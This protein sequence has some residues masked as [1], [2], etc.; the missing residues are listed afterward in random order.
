[1]RCLSAS[2]RQVLRTSDVSVREAGFLNDLA[3]A[4]L[5]FSFLVK[6]LQN[7]Q[8]QPAPLSGNPQMREPHAVELAGIK[9]RVL[10]LLPFSSLLSVST[11]LAYFAARV[12][13]LA[14][15]YRTRVDRL[16]VVN[17]ILYLITE[18]GIFGRPP[19]GKQAI[20]SCCLFTDCACASVPGF[21]NHL[22]RCLAF[23]GRTK[24]PHLRLLG[25][26]DLP[27]VDVLITCAGEDFETVRNTIAAACAL[28]YPEDRFRVVVLD[29]AGSKDLSDAV[30]KMSE[31]EHNLYY[32]ARVKGKDHHFKAGNLNHGLDFVSKLPDGPAEY[33]AA[34]DADMIPD[35]PFLRA[36][37]PHLIKNPK[38]AL[39]QLPQV[40]APKALIESKI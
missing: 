14:Q 21:L 10:N 24:A 33:V 19:K 7:T 5:F 20:P 27:R 35:P 25:N 9:Y 29:D 2:T 6:F 17:S 22:L 23:L 11:L 40:C 15:L 28:D 34:L 1:M 12:F 32:T 26:D 30:H 8:G 37:L 18:L 39:A 4:P 38:L 16:D 3:L 31:R 36:L 13:Q